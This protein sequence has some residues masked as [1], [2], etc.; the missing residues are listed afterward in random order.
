MTTSVILLTTDTC[1]QPFNAVLVR[2]RAYTATR[3]T[4][5]GVPES[6]RE[7]LDFCSTPSPILH[8]YNCHSHNR[9]LDQGA[10]PSFSRS[11]YGVSN[12]LTP[13]E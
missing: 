13:D 9:R 1:S 5:I 7:N 12:F 10:A 4:R 3:Y 8:L 6:L 2:T 11:L